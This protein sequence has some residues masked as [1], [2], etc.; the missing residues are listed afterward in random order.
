MPEDTIDQMVKKGVSEADHIKLQTAEALEEAARRIRAADLS[1]SGEDV[2]HIL[3]GVQDQMDQFRE[4]MGARYQEI[5]AGYHQKVE[6]VETMI[7]DH[8]IP[9]VLIAIGFG[10]L[11]GMLVSRSQ[12]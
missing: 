3:H 6:P 10:F 1:K 5:E 8:P 4:K 11:F 9:A 7:C 12:D 2:R